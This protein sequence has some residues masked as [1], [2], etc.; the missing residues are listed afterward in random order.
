[1]KNNKYNNKRLLLIAPL[2]FGYYKEILKEAENMGMEADY[3]CD[4][5][6]NTN[7]S[8]A[9]ARIN[10]SFIKGATRK[11]FEKDV[12]P[13]VCGK[14]YDYVLLVAGMT[15]AFLPDMVRKL[16]KCQKKARFIMYQWDSEKNLPYSTHIHAFF[17]DIYT[18]DRIDSENNSRYKF[19][20]LFYT[21]LYEKAGAEANEKAEYDCS[22]V[23]TAHPQKYKDINDI[24]EAVK[25]KLPKQFIY[26]YMPSRLKYV[27]HKFTAPE[28]KGAAFSE[29][30]HEKLPGEKML[31][32]FEQSD[33]ILDAPQ[34]DQT[35]LTIRTIECL[36]AKKKLITTN[37]DIVNYDFYN[38]NNILVYDG[39]INEKSPFF[40]TDYKELPDEIYRKYSLR[41][42]L[43]TMLSG[44]TE[45]V[46]I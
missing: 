32:I 8:K 12:Y 29:F 2:F 40:T 16:R 44:V 42:W 3:I 33:C 26:H 28:Y 13:K 31:R 46:T 23:G 37:A 11:Y 45:E 43:D 6:S 25:R 14:H 27:F 30:E 38:K 10:K 24:S 41:S 22:Y 36:G 17:D 4:A 39:E 20:P 15:F 34:K 9:V 21:R 1:M 35:G 7:L 5:P 19:L 18:F